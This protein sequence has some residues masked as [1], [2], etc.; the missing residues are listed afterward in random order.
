MKIQTRIGLTSLVLIVGLLFSSL[1]MIV[2]FSTVYQ[3][4]ILQQTYEDLDASLSR[5]SDRNMHLFS[6]TAHPRTTSTYWMNDLTGFH[7]DLNK[8][9]KSR[10][11]RKMSPDFKTLVETRREQ[12]DDSYRAIIEP[13]ILELNKFTGSS[14]ITDES[15]SGFYNLYLDKTDEDDAAVLKQLEHIRSL[16]LSLVHFLD[17]YQYS[18]EALNDKLGAEVSIFINNSIYIVLVSISVILF[19]SL[20]ISSIFS[21]SIVKRVEETNQLVE[22]MTQ[23]SLEFRDTKNTGDE[24]D[25]LVYKYHTFS[26]GLSE[27]LDSLK[28]LFQDI[29]SSISTETD[30]T[31]FQERIVELGMD[32][33][34]A[35]GGMLFLAD[36]EK[37]ELHLV[38]R[39]GFCPPPFP[40]DKSITMVRKNVEEYFESHPLNSGT[41][42]FGN[43][44]NSGAPLF[45]KDNEESAALP[46]NAESDEWLF[47][48]SYIC[49]PLIVGRQLMGLL[50][51][52]SVQ[53]GRVFSDLDFT[54]IKAYGDYT[55]QSIDNVYKYQSLLENREIQKEIDIAAGI[56]K[57]LLPSRMPE[58]SIGSARIHS[59]PA[60]GISGDYFDAIRL[61]EDKI[62]FTVCDVAGKGVP[63]SM[64]MIMIRTI[65]HTI[66]TR[67]RAANT[68]LKELNYHISGR[69]GVDQYATMAVFI[70]DEKKREI[71]FSNAAHHPLYLF[72]HLEKQ[73]RSFDT[74]GLPI[75]VDKNSDFGHKRIRLYEQDYLFLF[76]DGLPEARSLSGRE[77]SA[78]QLLRFL[79]NNLEKTPENLIQAVDS[80]IETFSKDARQHDDQTFLALQIAN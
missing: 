19:L 15:L 9:L 35:D 40:L 75:G 58:F 56:Q 61:D 14:L 71:S 70:L 36:S 24:F 60:R 6:D 74:D 26:N 22:K 18:V 53:K 66:C 63:A 62:L 7:S 30:I 68:L 65:L 21:R 4:K 20:L 8:A 11:I 1:F 59:K 16:Q 72:R 2:R 13:F 73:F 69:I 27:R 31:D 79:S 17:L 54:F 3:L 43:I 49:L 41:P 33:I 45:V 78:E 80:F 55:A 51:F 5:F 39:T 12:W 64:L 32:S 37:N 34:S 38:Q 25:T 77:L 46:Y 28:S 47:I 44:I 76:T 52:N 67:H 57:R 48:A 10:L 23:G 42:V 50:V 29:G